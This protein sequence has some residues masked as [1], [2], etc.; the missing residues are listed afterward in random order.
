MGRGALLLSPETQSSSAVDAASPNAPWAAGAPECVGMSRRLFV[1]DVIISSLCI[2]ALQL[3]GSISPRD[4]A[5]AIVATAAGWLVSAAALF[6]GRDHMGCD[7]PPKEFLMRRF[8]AACGIL[9]AWMV[10]VQLR[11]GKL[12]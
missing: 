10:W 12:I 11:A 9:V 6:V 4:L 2:G 3:S 7:P 1:R 8:L 5:G